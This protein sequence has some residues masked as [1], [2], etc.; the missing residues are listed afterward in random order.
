[1]PLL[2]GVVGAGG[3]LCGHGGRRAQQRAGSG[4]D[5][6]EP[7]RDA[8]HAGRPVAHVQRHRVRIRRDRTGTSDGGGHG[9]GRLH[10]PGSGPGVRDHVDLRVVQG[11]T[12]DV[13]RPAA[14]VGAVREPRHSQRGHDVIEAVD[15]C[16]GEEVGAGGGDL[17]RTAIAQVALNGWT[18][19]LSSS[20]FLHAF[21]ALLPARWGFAAPAS[22]IDSRAIVPNAAPDALWLHTT[23]QWWT[24]VVWLAGLTAM[25]VFLTIVV[26]HRRL[27][28]VD[29][30]SP[31]IPDAAPT[32]SRQWPPARPP[33]PRGTSC[34][35]R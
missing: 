17:D 15:L 5:G 6:P 34:A 3:R 26:L 31:V 10:D 19:D 21:S 33:P 16:G 11:S 28:P 8:L 12:G 30:C 29:S 7:P 27:S 13:A 32:P 23:G 4:T 22:S 2:I 35:V 14:D 18:A 20:P 1:M 25:H 24:N 9:R